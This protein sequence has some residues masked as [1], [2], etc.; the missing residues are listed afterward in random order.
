MRLQRLIKKPESHY[1]FTECENIVM[2]LYVIKTCITWCLQPSALVQRLSALR[3]QG[4]ANLEK[5]QDKVIMR[6]KCSWSDTTQQVN[7]HHWRSDKEL[8]TS[9]VTVCDDHTTGCALRQHLRN[10]HE[11]KRKSIRVYFSSKHLF[12][13]FWAVPVQRVCWMSWTNNLIHPRG[14]S[15]P[16]DAYFERFWFGHITYITG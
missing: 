5:S 11:N 12:F 10:V 6:W 2:G 14:T 8:W 15:C 1:L 16:E 4:A 7:K 13:F 3:K 9:Y